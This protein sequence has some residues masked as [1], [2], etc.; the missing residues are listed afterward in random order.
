MQASQQARLQ[1]SGKRAST[2]CMSAGQRARPHAEQLGGRLPQPGGQGYPP[3]QPAPAAADNADC[4]G[5]VQALQLRRQSA[6]ELVGPC[7]HTA[8]LRG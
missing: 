2:N 1:A 6:E 3:M 5:E 8:V 4:D 7:D